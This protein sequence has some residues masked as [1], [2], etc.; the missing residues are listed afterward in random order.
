M[1]FTLMKSS[2]WDFEETVEINTLEDLKGL[3]DKYKIPDNTENWENPPLIINF[4]S[5]IIEIYD[6]YRE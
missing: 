2:D 6:Y 4:N 3:Q 1:E 5:H